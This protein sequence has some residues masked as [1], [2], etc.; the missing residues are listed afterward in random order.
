MH[1][2][3]SV[4]PQYVKL[5]EQFNDISTKLTNLCNIKDS[6]DPERFGQQEKEYKKQLKELEPRI[7]EL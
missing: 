7:N 2:A 4:V 3:K 1:S 5:C 6:I